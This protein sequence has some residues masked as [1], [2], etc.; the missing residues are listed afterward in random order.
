MAGGRLL[1]CRQTPWRA[2]IGQ[3][4]MRVVATHHEP[5]AGGRAIVPRDRNQDRLR[6]GQRD[7]SPGVAAATGGGGLFG[8]GRVRH[9]G[10]GGRAVDHR[11][12]AGP[13]RPESFPGDGV[14]QV[15]ERSTP[16]AARGLL[17]AP[18]RTAHRAGQP[19]L[20]RHFR[21]VPARV[22]EHDPRGAASGRCLVHHGDRCL[23]PDQQFSHRGDQL[24]VHPVAADG[25]CD[26]A[27]V[28]R[29]RSVAR[30]HPDLRRRAGA[31]KLAQQ[32]ALDRDDP[33][34][35]GK[36]FCGCRTRT[37]ALARR[38]R[39]S[40]QDAVPGQHEP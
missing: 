32:P 22:P 1:A 23:H 27:R 7:L 20:E 21:R 40:G 18:V 5:G 39:Q 9:V 12:V 26:L 10:P 28:S 19:V 13:R 16:G 36:R 3:G 14:A 35:A 31:G 11:L 29:R 2:A 4:Q 34:A 33:L 38:R 24:R 8:G 25:R 17:A 30:Q 6:A 37:G 15:Q